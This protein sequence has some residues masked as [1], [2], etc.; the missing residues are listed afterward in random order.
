MRNFKHYYKSVTLTAFLCTGFAAGSIAQETSSNI[1]PETKAPVILT[2]TPADGEENVDLSSVFEITFNSDMDE[3][4]INETTLWVY[5]SSA[6]PTHEVHGEMLDD[7]IRDRPATNNSNNSSQGISDTVNGT[8]SYSDKIAVFT[9]N[10]ELK[11]GTLYTF[12]VTT[13]VENLENIAL[14]NDQIWSFSTTGT[15]DSTYSATQNVNHGM[16]RY[17]NIESTS[18]TTIKSRKNMIDLG[19]NVQFEGIIL[20]MNEITREEGAI[21]NRRMFSQTS[22]TLDD[23]TVTE[24]NTITGHTTSTNR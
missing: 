11:E 19:K 2:T 12:T 18:D 4:T 1:N 13:G 24:P 15:S 8:I 21:L 20:A 22:I 10:E 16:D 3:T 9:P 23:N 7:Q 17:E 5:A 14:E 6:N